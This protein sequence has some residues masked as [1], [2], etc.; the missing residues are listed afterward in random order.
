MFEQ[1]FVETAV[2]GTR[3]RSTLLGAAAQCTLL[4]AAVLVPMV[5]PEALPRIETVVG[6]F[7]PHAPAPPPAPAPEPLAGRVRVPP[8]PWQ[9]R[10]GILTEPVAVPPKPLMIDEPPLTVAEMERGFG[11]GGVF[12]GDPRGL[13][14]GIAD[15]VGMQ[16]PIG[17]PAPPP[18]PPTPLVRKAPVAVEPLKVGGR[19]QEALLVRKVIP[20]YPALARAA[21]IS[22][23]VELVGRVGADG[24]IR[25][26]RVSSG[27][28]LLVNAA[29]DAVRQW[30]Y[31][32][33]LL[34]G[35]PV[36][37]IAPI[38]VTFTLN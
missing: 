23:V 25:E 29:V 33:T 27:H 1:A 35:E 9:M 32:P 6:I 11:R 18:P 28:P 19:V 8:R 26:L 31:R 15:S 21:R 3:A 10:D 37:V 12:G 13:P 4:T 16:V 24:R 7:T 34:N 22:G 5:F 17:R 38:T 2:P 14:F 36:E 20:V 30:V